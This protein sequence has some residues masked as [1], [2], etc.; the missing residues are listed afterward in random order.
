MRRCGDRGGAVLW[1]IL[2]G[3]GWW[4]L[5]R[6]PRLKVRRP[7]SR[8]RSSSI[9]VVRVDVDVRLVLVIVR[10]ELQSGGMLCVFLFLLHFVK[11][12]F[13]N[14]IFLFV[15]I[16]FIVIYLGPLGELVKGL[17]DVFDLHALAVRC[18]N[19]QQCLMSK[20]YLR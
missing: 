11:Q 1:G 16:V 13:D 2:R 14:S 6:L 5:V 8:V 19:S 10:A 4:L 15:F 20:H 17:R 3:G 7:C 9:G 12:V 18:P